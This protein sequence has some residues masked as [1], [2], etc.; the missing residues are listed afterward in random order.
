MDYIQLLELFGTAVAASWLTRI[1]T[2]RSRVRQE[3]AQATKAEAE[4]KKEQIEIIQ[5]LVDDIYK[6]TIEDLKQ[7]VRDLRMEVKEVREENARLKNEV[8]Q[9]RAENAL[10]KDENTKLHKAIR[11]ISPDA[12]PSLRG[13]NSVGQPRTKD[14]KFAKKEDK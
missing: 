10:L 12:L 1:L 4:A 14:G 11:E 6:P 2:I 5:Q 8:E 3:G 13:S 9:V 7:D